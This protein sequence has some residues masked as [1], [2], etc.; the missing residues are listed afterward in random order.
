MISVI[1]PLHNLGSKG[2]YCLRRCLDSL[3]A[4][5]YTDFEVLLM[6]NGSTDDTVD[7]A[8]EYC[9]KDNRFKL[10]ILDTVGIANARNEGIKLSNREYISFLDGDDTLS[11]NFFEK[12]ISILLSDKSIDFCVSSIFF[13]YINK[14]KYKSLHVYENSLIIDTPKCI[15]DKVCDTIWAKII[16]RQLIVSNNIDFNKSLYGCDDMLFASHIYLASKKYAICSDA[17]YFYTQNR[18]NQTSIVRSYNMLAGKFH[19]IESLETLLHNFDAYEENLSLL[20]YYFISQ[21]IGRAFALTPITKLS[22]KETIYI[23]KQYNNRIFST[24]LSFSCDYIKPWHIIW[25]NRFKKSIKFFGSIGGFL[26]IKFMRIYR[27]LFI[28]PFKIKWYK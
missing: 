12:M 3:L 17:Y 1:V 9:N 24:N 4:Q 26:F 27:N 10:H 19:L 2:D 15:N 7:V 21:F 20:N 6:E 25:F 16:K 14:D 13:F 28:Q 11:E 23:I 5:T 22:A 8:Q 18:S